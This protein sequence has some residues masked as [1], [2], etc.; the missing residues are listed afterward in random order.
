MKT[1]TTGTYATIY[2]P[3]SVQCAV[4]L[5]EGPIPVSSRY[6]QPSS[7]YRVI[8]VTLMTCRWL[9]IVLRYILQGTRVWDYCASFKEA[10]GTAFGVLCC[11]AL[12][13]AVLSVDLRGEGGRCVEWAAK[14][15]VTGGW[16]LYYYHSQTLTWYVN[17]GGAGFLCL[18]LLGMR[19]P[20][21]KNDSRLGQLVPDSK[22]PIYIASALFFTLSAGISVAIIVLTGLV[23]LWNVATLGTVCVVFAESQLQVSLGLHR[24]RP[25][26]QKVH[27]IQAIRSTM[28][29]NNQETSASAS[30]NLARRQVL[31]P[32]LLSH[33]EVAFDSDKR[34]WRR[35]AADY[36]KSRSPDTAVFWHEPGNRIFVD[37]PRR[38]EV[39]HELNE[40]S[41][42][43]CEDYACTICLSKQPD[44]LFRPCGHVL[45]CTECV[46]ALVVSTRQKTERERH[47]W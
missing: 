10:I 13:E 2:D 1:G 12:Y 28:V 20:W 34:S 7:T 35:A 16:H 5:P 29:V 6:F 37:E 21:F 17:T 47:Q 30:E 18:V 22:N 25:T 40:A 44:V 41:V 19:S 3:A 15:F 11:T 24:C 42:D 39:C 43:P 8:L 4:P 45:A 26:I 32:S 14:D 27:Q 46:H 33:L 36:L 31:N 9:L 23:K 38:V